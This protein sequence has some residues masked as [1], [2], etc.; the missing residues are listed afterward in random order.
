MVVLNE[1]LDQTEERK[2]STRRGKFS[3]SLGVFF[4]LI[5]IC[6]IY[7]DLASSVMYANQNPDVRWN[8]K[9]RQMAIEGSTIYAFSL[10]KDLLTL[11][12]PLAGTLRF[13]DLFCVWDCGFPWDIFQKYV[14]LIVFDPFTELLVRFLRTIL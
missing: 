12:E 14:A 8:E 7:V 5:P 3:V 11:S 6:S 13:I 4:N 10:L 1:I 9:V 2:D